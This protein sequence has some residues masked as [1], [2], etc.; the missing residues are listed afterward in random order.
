[1]E[2]VVAPQPQHL[3][4]TVLHHADRTSRIIIRH[5]GVRNLRVALLLI[6]GD[7]Q[8]LLLHHKLQKR[9]VILK[10]I[11]IVL[12]VLVVVIGKQGLPNGIKTFLILTFFLEPEEVDNCDEEG[13]KEKDSRDGEVVD[14]VSFLVDECLI[15]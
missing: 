8:L 3:L 7:I 10:L 9:V 5:K 15:L 6:S 4:L 11:E 12:V 14:E 2:L 1:M 13:D